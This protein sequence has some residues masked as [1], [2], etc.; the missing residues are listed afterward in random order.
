MTAM[1]PMRPIAG[2]IP[3]AKSGGLLNPI[4]TEEGKYDGGSV[5]D[6][7]QRA[8]LKVSPRDEIPF[9]PCINDRIA[10]AAEHP[11]A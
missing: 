8:S 11:S 6:W 9:S 3:K 7:R 4:T 2:D 5:I 10:T 1:Q